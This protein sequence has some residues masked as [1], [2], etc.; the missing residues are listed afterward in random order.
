MSYITTY[1]GLH[2]DPTEPEPG[3][4]DIGDIAHA[5]SLLCRANG[6]FKHFYSVVQHSVAC[7]RE[8]A[9]RGCDV[10]VIMGC[11]LHDGSEA[12]LS[13]V[14]R[15]IKEGLPH[16]LEIEAKL[17]DMIWEKYLLSPITDDEKNSVFLIDDQMLSLEFHAL[18]PEDI[19]EEY[20]EIKTQPDFSFRLPDD[21]EREFL[22]L[23]YELYKK[24]T[25]SPPTPEETHR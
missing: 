6:H 15:P 5:L 22:G 18:M 11:L 14:T 25:S 3:L 10:R 13:D 4:I 16:Y 8:A 1:S 12:Y 20:F 21:T 17:Q 9:A 2:F 23:F 7:A 19:N 24:L